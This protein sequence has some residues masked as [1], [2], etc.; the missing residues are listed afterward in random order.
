MTNASQPIRNVALIAAPGSGKTL[1]CEALAYTANAIDTMGTTDKG[2]TISDFELEEIHRHHSVSASL[3]QFEWKG[4]RMNVIDTPGALDFLSEVKSCLGVVDGVILVVDAEDGVKSELEKIWEHMRER[5]VPCLLFI[6]GLDKERAEHVT[7]IQQCCDA[8]AINGVPLTLPAGKDVTESGIID[9][10]HRTVISSNK[11][12]PKIQCRECSADDA[13]QFEETRRQLVENVAETNDQL[14][15]KYLV[16]GDL[17]NEDLVEGLTFGTLEGRIIP[18][19]CGSALHNAGTSLLLDAIHDYLPSPDDWSHTHPISGKD[20]H[21]GEILIREGH[22]SEPFSGTAFKTTIDPFMGRL[23]Y[24]R[25]HSGVLQAD[26]GFFNATQG[27]KEKGGHIFWALGKKFTQTRTIHAGDIAAIAKLKDTQTGDTLC[28]E[29]HQIQFASPQLIRPVMSFALEPKSTHDIDK[30]SVGLHK[31]V[32]EDPS[33]E[34]LR[35]EETK[36]MLISG[37]G[38]TH[39]DVT[40]EKL[41]RKYGVE[42][43][44]HTPKIPYKETIQRMAQAQGKYKKQTGGHGQYGDCWLQLDPLPH[45]SGFEFQNKI[46]G[47]AIPRNFIPAVEKGIVEAMHHGTVAEYPVVDIRVTVYDGSHHPVDS[48]E[49]AFKVAASM[50]FKKAMELAQPTLLEPIMLLEVTVPD[51]MVGTIIGDLNGRRGRIQ[52]MST[53]GHHQIVKAITPLAEI[54]QYASAL[55]SMTAGKGSYI[56]EFWGYEEVPREQRMKIVAEHKKDLAEVSSSAS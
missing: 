12:T 11:R 55:T 21:S 36:E 39:I 20:P 27:T 15:E 56:M 51:D 7:V 18:V 9:V 3:L 22:V 16:D 4:T 30:V 43:N 28:E 35:N 45:G 53:K 1:L 29:K 19:L 33:L 44:L 46:V 38:Q 25:V 42:V 26:S 13:P 5:G 17:S 6:N 14:V 49:M 2:N 47:G 31:L 10:I 48:S 32:E 24:V 54:L 52:G 8:L 41:K 34:F 23:T 40:L 37:V 50:G